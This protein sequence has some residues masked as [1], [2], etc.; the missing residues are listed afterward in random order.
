MDQQ[1]YAIVFVHRLAHH[2]KRDVPPQLGSL[3][4][5][6]RCV[7]RV[8]GEPVHCELMQR[9]DDRTIR[10]VR[11]FTAGARQFHPL[12]VSANRS[13]AQSHCRKHCGCAHFPIFVSQRRAQQRV[14]LFI[15]LTAIA[16]QP[17]HSLTA[18]VSITNTRKQYR[19][20]GTRMLF[21]TQMRRAFGHCILK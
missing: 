3:V 12:H 2:T 9:S 7:E 1:K 13:C 15:R 14:N 21:T 19:A 8:A 5:N 11:T 20:I 10:F 6:L 18:K 17:A 16:D 4:G